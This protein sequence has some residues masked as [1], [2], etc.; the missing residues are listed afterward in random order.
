MY[1]VMDIF[2]AS[3]F[4]LYYIY[5]MLVYHTSVVSYIILAL[6]H[7]GT[8]CVKHIQIMITSAQEADSVIQT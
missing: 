6:L 4:L 5:Q 2:I 1:L 3:I 7:A 8:E